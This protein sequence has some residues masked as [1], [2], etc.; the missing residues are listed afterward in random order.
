VRIPQRPDLPGH[1]RIDVAMPTA[2]GWQ[3]FVEEPVGHLHKVVLACDEAA[4]CDTLTQDGGGDSCAVLAGLWSAWMKAASA[5][6]TTAP[7]QRP[8]R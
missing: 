8:S 5:G 4:V 6:E 7:V 1:V 3:L 2:D